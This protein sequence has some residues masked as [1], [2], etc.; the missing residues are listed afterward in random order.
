MIAEKERAALS[1]TIIEP[2]SDAERASV[3]AGTM[4]MARGSSSMA[5]GS[6]IIASAAISFSVAVAE[7]FDEHGASDGRLGE[8]HRLTDAARGLRLA[9]DILDA[10]AK[11]QR[12]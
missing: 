6:M 1:A 12:Q 4:R 7:M 5:S 3:I 9:A 10:I 2:L 8:P 11:G